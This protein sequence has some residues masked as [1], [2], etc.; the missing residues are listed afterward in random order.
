[1]AFGGE[2]WVLPP[3]RSLAKLQR[4]SFIAEANH[5]EV[6]DI[7][8]LAHRYRL[9]VTPKPVPSLLVGSLHPILFASNTF[10]SAPVS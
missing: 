10:L 3:I 8:S 1:M 4:N 2:L 5:I 6:Q 9:F 7:L